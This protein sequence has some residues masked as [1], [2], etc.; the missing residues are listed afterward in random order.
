MSKRNLDFFFN[1]T[2]LGHKIIVERNWIL[3][4]AHPYGRLRAVGFVPENLRAIGK[5]KIRQV[6]FLTLVF[7][8]PTLEKERDSPQSTYT[9]ALTVR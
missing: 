8:R 1:N 3:S 9:M 4:P 6:G 7:Q 5:V 2:R